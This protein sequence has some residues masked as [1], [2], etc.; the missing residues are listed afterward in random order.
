MKNVLRHVIVDNHRSPRRAMDK[1]LFALCRD[2]NVFIEYMVKCKELFNQQFERF[3]YGFMNTTH[4]T[5]SCV[6]RRAVASFGMQ[7]GQRKLL[8]FMG[9][10]AINTL[11]VAT[12]AEI[13]CGHI[14]YDSGWNL[15][16]ASLLLGLL[17]AFVRPILLLL[18]LPLVF[19]TLGLFTLVI[20]A[21]LLYFV[22]VLLTPHFQV[23]T[24]MN[25]FWGALIISIVSIFLNIATG[26]SGSA[27]FTVTRR[28]PP[29]PPGKRDDDV[30][31]V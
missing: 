9:T 17:N 29:P 20:N 2:S 23:D 27:R 7:A 25:A 18:A 11:A 14:R 8:R 16:L 13:L 5:F 26:L 24:W 1:W 22:G 30:I 10:W 3:K 4:K 19:F 31:D 15:L 28:P 12:A 6:S 21:V